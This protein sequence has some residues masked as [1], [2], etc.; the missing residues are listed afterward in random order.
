MSCRCRPRL[1]HGA[2]PRVSRPY[3]GPPIATAPAQTLAGPTVPPNI[4]PMWTEQQAPPGYH[5]GVVVRPRRR[6]R[7]IAVTAVVLMLA[8]LASAAAVWRFRPDLLTYIGLDA[9]ATS[10]PTQQPPYVR[11]ATPPWLPSGWTKIVNDEQ[12]A[13]VVEGE[14]TNGGTCTYLRPGT[15][16][17]QRARF[18][19]S[20]CV[21]EKFVKDTVV[22]DGAVEAEMSVTKGCGGM[23]I[24]TGTKGY[25]ISV[26]ANGTVELHKLATDAPGTDSRMSQIRPPMNPQKVVLGLL[27]RG[28]TLTVFVDGR[29]QGTLTDSSIPTGRVAI[30]GFAP[31]PEDA[32][33]APSLGSGHGPQPAPAPD[34]AWGRAVRTVSSQRFFCAA[35]GAT[36]RAPL[37]SLP[38]L[39]VEVCCR[40]AVG[41]D[42]VISLGSTCPS[43]PAFG[44]SSHTTP[45]SASGPRASTGSRPG[46]RRRRATTAAPRRRPRRCPR[47]PGLRQR[48]I[49]ASRRSSSTS[50]S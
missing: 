6:G 32:L 33:D 13:C 39:T 50:S 41:A 44:V 46:R 30:G 29:E 28:T 27:A 42:S 22:G 2:S 19:V 7:R 48:S 11:Q 49:R 20:G 43:R 16:R 31:H 18:D 8:L 40:P 34:A 4:H 26:C 5:P 3:R 9:K 17:V 38:A 36:S 21:A 45:L 12:R 15:V 23:W 25:F 47:R 10:T 37:Q 35:R 1:V 14:A 24:R